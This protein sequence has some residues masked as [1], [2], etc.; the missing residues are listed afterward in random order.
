MNHLYSGHT[1]KHIFH[2]CWR[3]YNRHNDFSSDIVGLNW[4]SLNTSINPN[5]ILIWLSIWNHST[6]KI[7]LFTNSL[8]FSFSFFFCL[9]IFLSPTSRISTY[10][11][12]IHIHWTVNWFIF[13]VQ[14]ERLFFLKY[15]FQAIFRSVNNESP[16]WLWLHWHNDWIHLK[17]IQ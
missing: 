10:L 1:Y 7:T 12:N 16:F 6:F 14:N 3:Q 9:A 17:R 8:R 13:C 5:S 4:F 2:L 11:S 15:S